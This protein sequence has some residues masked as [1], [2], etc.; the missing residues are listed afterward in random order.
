MCVLGL[1]SVVASMAISK[2]NIEEQGKGMY[3]RVNK[4]QDLGINI[5]SLIAKQLIQR[6]AIAFVDDM[7]FYSSRNDF[8]E[9]IQQIVN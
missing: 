4:K 7:S 2:M 9:K 8:I 1:A 6:L 3:S 5:E